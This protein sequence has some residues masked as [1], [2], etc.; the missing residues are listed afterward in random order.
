MLN[1]QEYIN[2]VTEGNLV[3]QDR[4]NQFYDGKTDTK[5]ADVAFEQGS[6]QRHN[7]S[8]QGANKDATLFASLS[9]LSNDGPI[10]GNQAAVSPEP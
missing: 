8:F 3:S 10:I 2:W 1:A 5:W 6:M 7:V 9:Y 4:I